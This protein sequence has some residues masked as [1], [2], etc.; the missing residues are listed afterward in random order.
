ML[1]KEVL[2]YFYILTIAKQTS[3]SNSPGK[4][5][6]FTDAVGVTQYPSADYLSVLVQQTVQVRLLEVSRQVG[7]VEVRRVLFLLL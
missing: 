1:L 4:A 5:D 6:T 3:Y 7:D 2:H